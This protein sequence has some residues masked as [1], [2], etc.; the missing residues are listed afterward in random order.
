MNNNPRFIQKQDHI[1]DTNKETILNK[2]MVLDILN[3]LNNEIHKLNKTIICLRNENETLNEDLM[4]K[5]AFEKLRQSK[6]KY[7]I[8]DHLLYDTETNKSYTKDEAFAHL[9]NT[10]NNIY[11]NEIIPLR[12]QNG[13]LNT[14]KQEYEILKKG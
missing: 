11:F 13:L 7:I 12:I 5:E 9:L 6:D 8:K 3:Q 14:Y 4:E 10:I 1:Y 2:K